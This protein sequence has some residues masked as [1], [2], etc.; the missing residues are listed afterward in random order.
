MDDLA[1]YTTCSIALP[2]DLPSVVQLQLHRLLLDDMVAA[3]T[4]T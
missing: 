1:V 4:T 3:F 2:L